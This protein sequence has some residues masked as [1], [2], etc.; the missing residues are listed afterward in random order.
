[1]MMIMMTMMMMMIS[2]PICFCSG[3]GEAH[4]RR[5]ESREGVAF[6]AVNHPLTAEIQR[7]LGW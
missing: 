4:Q 1:M 3:P 5:A 7:N 2:F 6:R